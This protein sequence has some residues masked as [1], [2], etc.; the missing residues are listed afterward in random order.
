MMARG[1]ASDVYLF[2][3]YIYYISVLKMYLFVFK[4]G[5]EWISGIGKMLI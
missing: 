5:S 4:D 3:I 2:C 1:F